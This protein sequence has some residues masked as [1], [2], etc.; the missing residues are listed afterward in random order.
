MV[1]EVEGHHAS[2]H[3]RALLRHRTAATATT[4]G[5][6]AAIAT[7][8]SLPSSTG[9]RTL[10]TSP[11]ASLPVLPVAITKLMTSTQLLP[12]MVL[13][14]SFDWQAAIHDYD[15]NQRNDINEPSYSSLLLTELSPI[16][17]LCLRTMTGLRF[18]CSDV[19]QL[20][21]LLQS[22]DALSSSPLSSTSASSHKN[23][24]VGPLMPLLAESSSDPSV[25]ACVEQPRLCNG[26]ILSRLLVRQ[27]RSMVF[28][29]VALSSGWESESQLASLH[30]LYLLANSHVVSSSQSVAFALYH[31]HFCSSRL[32]IDL[33]TGSFHGANDRASSP[34]RLKSS[35]PMLAHYAISMVLTLLESEYVSH[36]LIRLFLSIIRMVLMSIYALFDIIG[37]IHMYQ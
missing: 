6:T 33:V 5:A 13:L 8:A 3:A 11:L 24:H 31:Q 28:V 34:E 36:V 37:T 23:K 17:L 25:L 22:L 1:H 9:N 4:G 18:L 2:D 32:A 14:L 20:K 12:L 10:I 21:H 26:G 29:H 7:T 19:L 16:L 15:T 35:L 27:L 30:Y